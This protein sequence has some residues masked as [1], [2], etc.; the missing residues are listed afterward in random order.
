MGQFALY[1]EWD[2]WPDMQESYV[3]QLDL[4]ALF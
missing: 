2:N 4:L 3:G 1:L